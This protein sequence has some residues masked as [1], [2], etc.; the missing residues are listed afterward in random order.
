MCQ[1]DLITAIASVSPYSQRT[2]KGNREEIISNNA[3]LMGSRVRVNFVFSRCV[4]GERVYA[5]T[6]AVRVR[7]DVDSPQR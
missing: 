7:L 2:A 5:N 4:L 6:I 3:A 1:H